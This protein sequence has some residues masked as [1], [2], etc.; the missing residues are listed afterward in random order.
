MPADGLFDVNCWIGPWA[1]AHEAVDGARELLADMDRLG[2]ERALV[3]HSLAWQHAPAVG[4]ALLTQALQGHPRLLPCWG[5]LPTGTEEM[6][7]TEALCADLA[8]HGV[9]AVRVYPRD[10]AYPLATWMCWRLLG[11]LAERRYL[12][13]V[14]LE[15]LVPP[16]GLYDV[17]TAGWQ[18]VAR[19][20]KTCPGLSVVLTR[21]GYRV[22][23]VLGPLLEATSNLYLDLSY[24]ATHEGVEWLARRHGV[25]RLLFGT[26]NPLV[27]PAGAVTRLAYAGIAAQERARIA[28]GNL[29]RLLGQVSL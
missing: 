8:R 26:G 28:R 7:T 25:D 20:C 23:R 19:I 22:L 15:Q 24:F 27:D 4:N 17:T 18:D 29:E 13:L 2:I 10:H 14:D 12:F 21:V 9:R 1:D 3:A 6:G 5:I 11:A 16:T